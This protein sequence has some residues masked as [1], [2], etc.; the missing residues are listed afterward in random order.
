[1][2]KSI[3]RAAR[4]S[5][6]ERDSLPQAARRALAKS[7][8]GTATR[9]LRRSDQ[10]HPMAAQSAAAALG[11]S[12]LCNL[13]SHPEPEAD[14]DRIS[15]CTSLHHPARTAQDRH[16]HFAQLSSPRICGERSALPEGAAARGS[17]G[18]S[19][20]CFRAPIPTRHSSPWSLRR[21]H[22]A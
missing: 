15:P 6:A 20:F 4:W 11:R 5:R 3:A 8:Q 1:M 13:G 21:L 2:T 17:P 16:S 18:A 14:R 10:L 22:P 12:G 9:A 19:V 7:Y